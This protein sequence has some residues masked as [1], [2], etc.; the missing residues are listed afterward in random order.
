MLEPPPGDN[1]L[2]RIALRLILTCV[3][4]HLESWVVQDGEIPE[5]HAGAML[6]DHDLRAACWSTRESSAP[7]G[8][9]ELAGPDPSGDDAPHYEL[10]GTVERGWEP[11]SV[12]LRVGGFRVLAEPCDVRQVP[13]T[14]WENYA[15]QRFSP[16][17][18]VPPVATRVTVVCR[19]EVMADHE[20]EDPGYPEMRHDW[21]VRRLKLQHRAL[22]SVPGQAM[23]SSIGRVRHEVAIERMRRWADE[24]GAGS[25]TYLLDLQPPSGSPHPD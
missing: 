2:T 25:V 20:T 12:L 14:T 16:G 13:G 24:Q 10:T 15:V 3:W 1:H 22:A 17:F 5:L 11:S 18:V 7:E 23:V 6:H 21:L 19:L 4:A 8:L 9:T